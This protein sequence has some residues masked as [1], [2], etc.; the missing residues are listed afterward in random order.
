MLTGS[1]DRMEV[2]FIFHCI[3]LKGEADWVSQMSLH[4]NT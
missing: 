1:Q 2:A 3:E 4:F